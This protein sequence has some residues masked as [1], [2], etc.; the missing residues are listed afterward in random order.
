MGA[1]GDGTFAN[2]NE[3]AFV[4]TPAYA[5]G[6]EAVTLDFD[7]GVLPDD[8]YRL[9]LSGTAAIYDTAGNAL[10]GNSNGQAGMIMSAISR[11][12]GLPIMRLWR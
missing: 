7:E 8:Y 1:G 6:S 9:T 10:D 12:T 4:V 2:G 5:F 11:S 3:V